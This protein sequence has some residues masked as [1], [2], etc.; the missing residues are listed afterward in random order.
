MLTINFVGQV[1]QVEDKEKLQN[2]IIQTSA[3]QDEIVDLNF[4]YYI[5]NGPK[6][7]QSKFYVVTGHLYVYENKYC[8]SIKKV[9]ETT[10]TVL[11]VDYTGLLA[12]VHGGQNE[13]TKYLEINSK[14]VLKIQMVNRTPV[15]D[16][17]NWMDILVYNDK[18][19]QYLEKLQNGNPFYVEGLLMFGSYTKKDSDEKVY[20]LGMM[21]N[22]FEFINTKESNNEKENTTKMEYNK[23]EHNTPSTTTASDVDDIPF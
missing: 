19:H 17:S 3:R 15:K 6:L 23:M 7:E 2:G 22:S 14:R 18:V 16:N 12:K 4:S 10:D 8:V 13:P 11:A 21:L 1:S 9:R 20:S 5:G